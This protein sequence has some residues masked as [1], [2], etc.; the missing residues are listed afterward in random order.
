ML[1]ALFLFAA[2]VLFLLYLA[3]P[4]E[5]LSAIAAGVIITIIVAAVCALSYLMVAGIFWL[6]CWGF[7]LTIWSWRLSF[8]FWVAFELL[9]LLFKQAS[10][11]GKD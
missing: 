10:K 4:T 11:G 1:I 3:A 8:G 6:I 7:G 2:L 5:I 9:C